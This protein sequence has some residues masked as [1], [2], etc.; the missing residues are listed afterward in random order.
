M[1]KLPFIILIAALIVSCNKNSTA[2]Q[3]AHDFLTD[4]LECRFDD[5]SKLLAEEN[6]IQQMMY[7]RASQLTQAEIELIAES[8]VE[9]STQDILERGDSCTIRLRASDALLLDSIGVTCRMGTIDCTVTLLK[10]KKGR[11]WKV[12]TLNFSY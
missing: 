6:D 7:W 11:N 10:G 4:Y 12:A 3:V 8:P 1:R 5:A 9:V 2:E